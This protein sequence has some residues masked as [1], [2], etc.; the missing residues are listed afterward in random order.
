MPEKPL[1]TVLVA[2]DSVE[3]RA[4]VSQCL[5]DWGLHVMSVGTGREALTFLR[6]QYFDLIVT[7]IVMPDADGIEVV[8][9]V[10]KRYRSTRILAM[11][12]EAGRLDPGFCL[13]LARKMGAHGTLEK[14]FTIAQ[15][16]DAI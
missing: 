2:D 4:M 8:A 6:S 5:E 7:D 14:P 9:D 11:C 15:L 3:V 1:R 16:R 13:G 12:G 10:R